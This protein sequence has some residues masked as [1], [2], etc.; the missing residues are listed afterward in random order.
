MHLRTGVTKKKHIHK[1]YFYIL[2]V[3]YCAR[4][5]LQF[6]S[7]AL[8]VSLQ[9]PRLEHFVVFLFSLLNISMITYHFSTSSGLNEKEEVFHILCS[10]NVFLWF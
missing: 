10:F 2:F 1:S 9:D 3:W 7:S 4:V 5:K 8:S 6:T